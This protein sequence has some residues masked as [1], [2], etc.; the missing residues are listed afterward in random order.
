M[1]RVLSSRTLTQSIRLSGLSLAA[2]LYAEQ[3]ASNLALLEAGTQS[4]ATRVSLQSALQR[5][6]SADNNTDANWSRAQT[7][8]ASALVGGGTAQYLLQVQ[9]F[10]KNGTGSAGPYPL[11]NVTGTGLGQIALPYDYPNGTQV[12]LGDNDTTGLGY[13][14][15]LYPNLTYTSTV[16]ND[17]FNTSTAYF[18]GAILYPN[19]TIFLGPLQVNSSYALVSITVAVINNTSAT[20]IIGWETIVS[21]TSLITNV[22]RSTLGL[23]NTGIVLVVAPATQTN[24]YPS[25]ILYD[26]LPKASKSVINAQQVQYALPP[27]QDPNRSTRH[28]SRAYGKPNTP[29]A[30][31]AYPSL[32]TAVSKDLHV[33][34][35]A[36]SSINTRNEDNDQVSVGFARADSDMADWFVIVEQAHSEVVQPIN[37][38]RNVLIA[39]VFGVVGGILLTLLPLAHYS[40]RPIR[41]LRDAT[42]K[43]VEPYGFSSD[44][45]SVRASS[46]GDRE[47][48]FSGD[49]DNHAQEAKKEGFVGPLARWKTGRQRTREQKEANRRRRET[50]RIPG[51]VPDTKHIV[52]DEL[53]D[54]TTTFNEM[55][56][57]LMMQYERLEERVR[58]RTQ[59]LELSKKAAEAANESK[60]LFIANISHE[61]KTPLNGILG[62]CAVCM[63][64]EDQTKIKRSLG[65][66]YKSGDLLLHLL[67]DLL[68]FSKN[69]IGQQLALDEREFRIADISS[70]ILSIFEKQAK[71]G[72]INLQVHFEGPHESLETA[73]GTPGQLGYGPYGTGRVR[74]MCLWGDQHRILQVIIN[75]VSNSL[76]FTPKGGTVDVR[77]RC[78]GEVESERSSSSR[79]GSTQSRLSKVPSRTSKL[80]NRYTSGSD[81]S[82]PRS[83]LLDGDNSKDLNTALEIN[84]MEPKSISNAVTYERSPSPA[85][86]N[87]RVLMFEFEVEDSGPGI[88]PAQ[89]RKVFEPFVQGDLGLSKKFGGTG[90]G[91]SIC[92]QL[93]K[94]MKGSISLH[95]EEGIGSRF[96]MSIPLK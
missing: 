10:S 4:I 13:P 56:E 89:Q 21:D 76:K 23:G 58:V 55:S 1:Q 81:Q 62:M 7:D 37:H 78:V 28:A 83:V 59:E 84:S 22:E 54:L 25:G 57:E 61:L 30:L 66:I 38:L 3:L 51:K 33:L 73:S 63:Q 31:S 19:T 64:E 52:H 12:F 14:P 8:L 44:D 46:H 88:A 92:S 94:L 41:R 93:A 77:I 95:S 87:A 75:L 68:T 6:D 15:S 49:E 86:V 79:K 9:V 20:D 48:V 69:Q 16:V 43:T 24:K 85:P 47:G 65:I 53:T 67:T 11:V 32:Q 96:T 74:D 36:G 71:E 26:S 5:Y 40:V 80:L 42:K 39:C 17:T 45:G 29:F 91:L 82:V 50:F 90:L 18:N 60:T 27:W 2:S 70:Q 35:N 34:N 72:A